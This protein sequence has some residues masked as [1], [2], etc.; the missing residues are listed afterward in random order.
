L[1]GPHVLPHLLS[2]N[3]YRDSLLHDLPKL[4][5]DVPLAVRARMWYMHD[6]APAHF[7]R[8]VRDVLSNTCHGRWIGRGGPTAWPPPSPYLNPMDIYLWEHLKSLC[9]QLLLT[10]KRHFTVALWMAVKLSATIPASLNGCG[11][12]RR[13]VE[14]YFKFHGGHLEHLL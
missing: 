1:V 13:H 12:M 11:A 8:A 7:S 5:E 4:L 3:H 14:A 10:T 2:G 9:M 6:C